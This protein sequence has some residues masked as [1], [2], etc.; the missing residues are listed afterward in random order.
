MSFSRCACSAARPCC[1][2][3][4]SS[5]AAICEWV[6]VCVFR[7]GKLRAVKQ[8]HSWLGSQHHPC[9]QQQV[10]L[11]ADSVPAS[12]SDRHTLSPCHPPPPHP[13]TAAHLHQR[14]LVTLPIPPPPC[15]PQPSPA[16]PCQHAH[17]PTLMLLT[18]FTSA[19]PSSTSRSAL[20]LPSA[21]LDARS[22]STSSP[23]DLA[24]QVMGRGSRAA[25]ECQAAAAG[26][27]AP[28]C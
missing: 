7:G 23:R 5:S 24:V 27:A 9:R 17:P 15:C 11:C 2:A 3:T 19:S 13:H 4:L 20:A 1:P 12:L 26:K 8:Y 6:S 16:L 14:L 25:T 10:Q 28:G 22:C 18:T 21:A